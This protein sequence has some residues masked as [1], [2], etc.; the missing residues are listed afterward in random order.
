MK[1]VVSMWRKCIHE[2]RKIEFGCQNLYQL[3]TVYAL[4]ASELDD[5]SQV[6]P[7]ETE[8]QTWQRP[9]FDAVTCYN[10]GEK[11]NHV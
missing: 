11:T 2:A 6:G 5:P 4:H 9:C 1:C 10:V 8:A 3:K 7:N